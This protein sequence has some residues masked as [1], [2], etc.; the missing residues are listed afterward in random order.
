M[1]DRTRAD[2]LT[3]GRLPPTTLRLAHQLHL[4]SAFVEVRGVLRNALHSALVDA[5]VNSDAV[6]ADTDAARRYVFIRSVVP[7]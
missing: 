6:N 3:A 1:S 5:R 4:E 2:R 7:S